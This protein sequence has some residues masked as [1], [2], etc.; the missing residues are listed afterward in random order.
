MT[1]HMK[2]T[3]H[4]TNII[5]QEQITS[6]KQP[7]QL[8]SQEVPNQKQ[9]QQNKQGQAGNLDDN[10]DDLSEK[11]HDSDREGSF[12]N[13]D[14]AIDSDNN[15][16][17]QSMLGNESNSERPLYGNA[18][19]EKQSNQTRN[20]QNLGGHLTAKQSGDSAENS[21]AE[22]ATHDDA[23]FMEATTT[24][25]AAATA[26]KSPPTTPSSQGSASLAAKHQA[27]SRKRENANETSPKKPRPSQTTQGPSGDNSPNLSSP[28]SR[29]ERQ[30]STSSNSH[31]NNNHLIPNALNQESESANN[32]LG[33]ATINSE[34]EPADNMSV[35]GHESTAT[36]DSETAAADEDLA[37]KQV[38]KK[39][40]DAGGK[41]NGETNDES[42][43]KMDATALGVT[44]AMTDYAND[45]KDKILN[46][47]AKKKKRKVYEH[48][49]TDCETNDF[50]C[51]SEQETDDVESIKAHKDEGN[52]NNS[53]E[54]YRD[55]LNDEAHDNDNDYDN[56]LE[57]EP[58]DSLKAT[59]GLANR[60]NCATA[61]NMTSPQV[62]TTTTTT[63]GH[64]T[65]A[66]QR[67]TG[68][69]GGG[70]KGDTGDPLSA[71]ETMVEKSFDP[72]LRPGVAT[73]GILQRLGIDEE[74]CPPWQHINYANWYAAAAYGHPMAA[75]LLAAG[76]NLQNGIKLSKNM[77]SQ[78][79]SDDD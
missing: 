39:M 27:R 14:E 35:T 3:Q 9:Q 48:Q 65:N 75:A 32:K 58:G 66:N 41:L 56:E 24:P 51:K 60:R 45:S 19:P 71:L 78:K 6:W 22:S 36:P 30:N 34:N 1:Q 16:H 43:L 55:D 67:V 54:D 13:D 74:V 46:P 4:Y 61:L 11:F 40:L 12:S 73:G 68:G 52:D 15:N 26:I 62:T 53:N 47:A 63:P 5:S 7:D 44:D 64:P 2:V 76:I 18:T 8:G 29:H 37:I 38:I 28:S 72:R 10:I 42:N 50:R 79:K 17:N 23:S 20:R 70:Q 57:S 25:A 33:S 49:P 77:A 59:A 69:V 21:N 31:N